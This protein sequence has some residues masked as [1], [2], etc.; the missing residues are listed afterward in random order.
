MP[1][2]SHFHEKMLETMT[3]AMQVC[4]AVFDSTG[5]CTAANTSYCDAMELDFQQFKNLHYTDFVCSPFLDVHVK[6]LDDALESQS[7][8][9][10][11]CFGNLA[12]TVSQMRRVGESPAYLLGFWQLPSPAAPISD[13]A[14]VDPGTLLQF[15]HDLLNDGTALIE[16]LR[17][18]EGNIPANQTNVS[19][20]NLQYLQIA[21]DSAMMIARRVTELQ[22]RVRKS[23]G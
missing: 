1:N 11:Y 18:L 3:G 13:S 19:V 10:V 23:L 6:L 9:P 16:L 12:A 4:M 5:I 15:C 2:R 21:R 22:D 14:V 20:E 17:L 8:S 7:T